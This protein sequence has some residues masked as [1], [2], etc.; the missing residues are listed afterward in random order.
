MSIRGG[1]DHSYLAYS[2]AYNSGGYEI[3]ACNVTNGDC[4]NDSWTQIHKSTRAAGADGHID[5]DYT[6]PNSANQYQFRVREHLDLRHN[7][8]VAY[9]EWSTAAEVN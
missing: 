3:E 8:E 4:G 2:S 1:V 6:L 7:S 5:F 9:S